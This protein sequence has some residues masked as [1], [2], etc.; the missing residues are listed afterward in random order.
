L[1]RGVRLQDDAR[2]GDDG[3]GG[4]VRTISERPP[5]A[6]RLSNRHWAALDYLAGGVFGLI[7]LATI[8]RGVVQAIESDGL[9]PYRPLSL[10]W[11]LAVFLI[12]MAVVAV[13]MRRRRPAFML[14]ILLAGSVVVTALTGPWPTSC[15]SRT[16]STWSRRPTST[17]RSRCACSSRCSPRCSPTACS[18]T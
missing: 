11:P 17:G 8:R 3:Y 16:S 2:A 6:M 7:L 10:T 12:V 4:S 5:L 1:P 18:S 15:P 14:G 9:M 13:G